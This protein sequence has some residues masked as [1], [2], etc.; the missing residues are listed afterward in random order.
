MIQ[1][2]TVSDSAVESS[3]HL[4]DAAVMRRLISASSVPHRLLPSRH[5]R[6]FYRLT[7]LERP[8]QTEPVNQRHALPFHTD[9]E[10]LIATGFMIRFPLSCQRFD[11]DYNDNNSIRL[12]WQRFDYD[13]HD[14]DSITIIMATIQLR[15][16]CQRLDYDYD[17]HDND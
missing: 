16:S 3:T 13:Y 8:Q 11:S 2:R 1:R 14:N 6:L 7:L 15:L 10:T 17:Y 9:Q 5:Q 4:T 12:S